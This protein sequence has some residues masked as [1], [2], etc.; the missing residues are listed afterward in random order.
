MNGLSKYKESFNKTVGGI[1]QGIKENIGEYASSIGEDIVA[2]AAEMGKKALSNPKSLISGA[3][4]GGI[5]GALG[6]QAV[7]KVLDATV[8]TDNPYLQAVKTTASRIG[9]GALGGATTGGVV[10][11]TMGGIGGAISDIASNVTQTAQML[12][13]LA[14]TMYGAY[15]EAPRKEQELKDRLAARKQPPAIQTSMQKIMS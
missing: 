9:G 1:S 6:E 3:V 14:S 11:A 5:A 10:G 2:G 7:G 15:V 12:P 4:K 8:K 13:E